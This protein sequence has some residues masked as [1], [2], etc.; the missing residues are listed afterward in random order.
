MSFALVSKAPP[1]RIFYFLFHGS[2][3]YIKEAWIAKG[4]GKM[5]SVPGLDS[6]IEEIHT[7]QFVDFNYVESIV[8]VVFCRGLLGKRIG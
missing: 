2:L 8:D 1:K 4:G 6:L 5:S 3:I 7:L